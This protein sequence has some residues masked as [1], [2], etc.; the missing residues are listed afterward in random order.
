MTL[1]NMIAGIPMDQIFFLKKSIKTAGGKVTR[2][3]YSK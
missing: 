3:D 2:T 1:A